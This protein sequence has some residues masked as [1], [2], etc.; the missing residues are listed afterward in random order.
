MRINCYSEGNSRDRRWLLPGNNQLIL[1]GILIAAFIGALFLGISIGQEN[2]FETYIVLLLLGTPTLLFILKGNYWLF[3]PFV[4]RCGLPAIPLIA[5]RSVA[6]KEIWIA[7]SLSMLVGQLV[8]YR[9]RRP[10]FNRLEFIPIYV[11]FA[12]VVVMFFRESIGLAIMGS[13]EQGAR[14]YIG[15]FLGIISI[16]VIAHQ[17]ISEKQ[18]KWLARLVLIATFI[19]SVFAL[20]NYLFFR[21]VSVEAEQWASTYYTYH[22]ILSNFPLILIMWIFSKYSP[23]EIVWKVKLWPGFLLGFSYSLIL[24]SGKRMHLA[25]VLLLPIIAA[26]IRKQYA[27]AMMYSAAVMVFLSMLIVVQGNIYQLPGSVER[28]LSFVN[29]IPGVEWK[30]TRGIKKTTFRSTLNEIALEK[31]AK[32]P[33]IG[34]GI[35]V[36]ESEIMEYEAMEEYAVE[37]VDSHA[38]RMAAGSAWHNTW[39]GIS[40][41]F[42]I[43]CTMVFA[44]LWLQ[45]FRYAFRLRRQLPVGSYARV[46]VTLLLLMNLG[47]LLQS[48][49][50]GH[51]LADIIWARGWQ[52]GIL[53][54]LRFNMTG[55]GEELTKLEQEKVAG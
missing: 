54:A 34:N 38:Y 14:K 27:A 7:L 40:T 15:I 46:L 30:S 48:W 23:A 28:A 42:G 24:Y 29:Y 52:F 21:V 33:V 43:P 3:I 6:L 1:A 31:I 55:G 16:F 4:I 20:V 5:G 18:C 9:S 26:L 8:L 2:Y 11:I 25:L 39:L 36:S 41:D 45:I 12:W 49:V 53:L 35:S 32:H 10:R 51:S 50:A 17:K 44:V 19:A 13:E 37:D 22:Q 47:D